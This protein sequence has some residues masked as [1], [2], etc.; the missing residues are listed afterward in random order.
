MLDKLPKDIVWKIFTY[1]WENRFNYSVHDKSNPFVC[2]LTASFGLRFGKSV[3]SDLKLF[4]R[5]CKHTK[6]TINKNTTRYKSKLTQNY[7]LIFLYSNSNNIL[8]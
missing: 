7:H 2:K 5:I 6:H 3:S 1:L 8:N 4:R